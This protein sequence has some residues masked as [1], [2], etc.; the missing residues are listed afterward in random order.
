[1]PLYEGLKKR[2][3]PGI[4]CVILSGIILLTSS[5]RLFDP[6][7]NLLLD[8][9]FRLRPQQPVSDKIVI[10][11][12]SDDTLKNLSYWPLPRDFH[13]SLV[14]ILTFYG[15]KQVMFDVLFVEPSPEDEVLYES[16]KEAKNVYLPYVF[17]IGEKVNSQKSAS[18]NS[19]I[20]ALLPKLEEAA[21]GTG[22]INSYKDADGKV[23]WAPLFVNFNAK[24]EP[25][26][27]LRMAC[28][29]LGIPLQNIRKEDGYLLLSDS[30]K[31]PVSSGNS[32]LVNYAGPWKK[33]FRHYSY[34]DILK[35]F[36]DKLA[37]RP[38]TLDLAELKDVVCFIGLTATG[39]SDLHAVPLENNYPMVGLHA[40]ILNSIIL[41][42]Y[43]KRASPLVNNLFILLLLSGLL[44]VL[45]KK[46]G[47]PVIALACTAG[48]IA[49]YAVFGFT[50]F[51]FQ[52]LWI[53]LFYPSVLM[54]AVYLFA[55]IYYF[56]EENKKRE[57]IEK[58]LSIA[59][60]I[61]E[62][63]LPQVPSQFQ[64]LDIAV[65]MTTAKHVGGD[66]YDV[67][68]LGPHKLGILIGDVSGKGVGAA[69]FM[70]KT[71][72]L[73]RMVAGNS[74][75]P[76]D[77][78][79]QLNEGM[80]KNLQAGIFVTASYLIYDGR[81]KKVLVASGGHSATIIIRKNGSIEKILPQE[82]M[83]LGL[84]GQVEFSQ[85]EILLGEKDRIVLYTDGVV[86]AKNLQRDDFGE[87]RLCAALAN[88][89]QK[90]SQEILV[91]IEKD[92]QS[93]VGKAPQHDDCTLMVL[94]QNPQ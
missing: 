41:N 23:R 70:A 40:S 76:S 6:Y 43:L 49:G 53:D 14:D 2:L 36:D 9:R 86:E 83:P 29:Y 47:K 79:F 57:L 91:N 35:S 4:A 87:E 16:I 24:Q 48:F 71:I 3:I 61:Q 58:E 1:M 31:I 44:A 30:V 13:A 85:E 8:L 77:I 72:S 42:R 28:D 5:L 56:L 46:K 75:E 26:I 17:E 54:L 64:N 51:A 82:G 78:L 88:G 73:F 93:F 25:H 38:S 68:E 34:V 89:P 66:L 37:G 15:V 94:T 92:I 45:R 19:V 22:H 62:S 33:T 60:R 55:V 67:F 32:L 69:L 84:S 39:T 52:N 7:E 11:E 50:V 90:T 20:A 18:A 10:I 81:N 80:A 27:V 21:R 63:F 74:D 12:I 59:K 65:H